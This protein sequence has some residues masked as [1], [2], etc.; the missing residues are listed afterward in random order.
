MKTI[1]IPTLAAALIAASAAGL[2]QTSPQAVP[3]ADTPFVTTQAEGQWLASLFF[4]QV[5][6]N[7]AGETVG[8]INDLL[9]DKNGRISTAVVGVGGFLGVGEKSIAVPFAALSFKADGKGKRVV[10]LAMSKESLQAAPSFQ[11]NEKTL[12]M[13]AKE[14]ASEIGRKAG[15]KAGELRDQAARKIEDMRGEGPDHK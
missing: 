10:V 2:A 15:D 12:Y 3:V 4:G 9:F 1:I 7:E 6:T 13:R 11:P 5:V 14:R 8:D